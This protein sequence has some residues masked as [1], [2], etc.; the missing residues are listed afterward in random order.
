MDAEAR[1]CG[2]PVISTSTPSEDTLSAITLTEWDLDGKGTCDGLTLTGT[3]CTTT[4]PAAS[5]WEVT[6]TVT[7][8][9]QDSDSNTRKLPSK[10]RQTSPTNLPLIRRPAPRHRPA[11]RGPG[12]RLLTPFPIVTVAGTVTQAGTSIDL[13]MVRAPRGSQVLVRCHGGGAR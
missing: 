10:T 9:D 12:P 8:L 1:F 13:L 6:L 2:A 11:R 7:D 5:D 3:T 4:A